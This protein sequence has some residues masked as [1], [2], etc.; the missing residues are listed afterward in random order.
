MLIFSEL[1][2]KN[3]GKPNTA[4]CTASLSLKIAFIVFANIILF[5]EIAKKNIFL[6]KKQRIAKFVAKNV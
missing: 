6:L 3:S 2:D 5:Y 4:F 1:H